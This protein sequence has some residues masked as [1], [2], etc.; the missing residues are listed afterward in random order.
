MSAWGPLLALSGFLYHHPGRHV[1][2]KPRIHAE[3]FTSFWSAGDGWGVFSHAVRD[4]RLHFT[5]TVRAGNL[6]CRTVT[7]RKRGTGAG[8]TSASVGS[9]KLKH[10]VRRSGAEI[11][12]TFDEEVRLEEGGPLVV[13]V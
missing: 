8:G 1:V 10:Q 9:G 12:I 3:N 2:A 6:V 11:V 13:V 5:L 4:N 7:L